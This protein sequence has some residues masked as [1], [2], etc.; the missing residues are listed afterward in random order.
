[1]S[2]LESHSRRV[3]RCKTQHF[4]VFALASIVAL[5]ESFPLMF[6]K[7]E[8][9]MTVNEIELKSLKESLQDTQPVGSIVNCCRT[10]DQV[11]VPRCRIVSCIV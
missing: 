3:M 1:M 8:E 2:Y 11:N 7:Q 9:S 10:L 5:Q 4:F 6:V